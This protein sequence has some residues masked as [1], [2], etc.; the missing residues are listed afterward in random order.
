[1]ELRKKH[2][3][4]E[5]KVNALCEKAMVNK[6]TFYN[7]YQ[8]IYELSE[9]LEQEV[10]D[11]FLN[12]FQDID[13]MLMDS[14]RFINGMHTVLESENDML[15]IVFK[16]KMDELIERIEKRIRN[17]YPKEDQMLISFLIGGSI[18]LMMKSKNKNEEVERFLIEVITKIGTLR[19]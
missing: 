18:H 10:L 7:H 3:L 15:R 14:Q 13:M 5:I 4:E 17:Y 12:N 8:D 1:M 6:T 19:E 9:E 11:N 2:S 16:D